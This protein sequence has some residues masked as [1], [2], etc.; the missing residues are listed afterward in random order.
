[1]PFQWENKSREKDDCWKK[2][3]LFNADQTSNHMLWIIANTVQN[4]IVVNVYVFLSCCDCCRGDNQ[5]TNKISPSH[6]CLIH[7]KIKNVQMKKKNCMNDGETSKIFSQK[8][9][10]NQVTFSFP[11]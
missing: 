1:M 2:E 9:N 11:E 6:A 5:H 8:K 10:R 7:E 4:Q 3:Y